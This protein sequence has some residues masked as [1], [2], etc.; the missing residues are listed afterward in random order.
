MFVDGSQYRSVCMFWLKLIVLSQGLGN[1]S[2]SF[3]STS[4]WRCCDIAVKIYIC[5]FNSWLSDVKVGPHKHRWPSEVKSVF[6]ESGKKVRRSCEKSLWRGQKSQ[7]WNLKSFFSPVTERRGGGRDES[8]LP[9][10]PPP[11][12]LNQLCLFIIPSSL[13]C[14][15]FLFTPAASAAVGAK[16]EEIMTSRWRFKG[17]TQLKCTHVVYM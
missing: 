6:C 3:R 17:G 7:T 9:N 16:R 2:C 4:G 8:H 14:F 13:S 5:L 10:L 12:F 1:A 15:F 11:V